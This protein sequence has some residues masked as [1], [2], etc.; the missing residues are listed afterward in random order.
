LAATPTVT[1]Y[2]DEVPLPFSHMT[3]FAGL[4]VE[5][6][7]VLKGPQGTL[8]GE[9]ADGGAIN[10]IAAKPSS[11]LQAGVD[12]SYGRFND[13]DLQGFVSGPLTSTMSARLSA[14]HEGASG[15]QNSISRPGDRNG[16]KNINNARLLIDWQPNDDLKVGLDVNGGVDRSE[17]Q[18]AQF[19]GITIL[20]PGRTRV[21]NTVP[22]LF[23]LPPA[24][25]NAQA[26]DWKAGVPLK[27]NDSQFQGAL[28]INYDLNSNIKLASITSYVIFNEYQPVEADGTQ[29]TNIGGDVVGQVKSF[30]QE[31]RAQ[32]KAFD[33]LSW[34]VGA[35]YQHDKIHE[36]QHTLLPD[37]GNF[38]LGITE[39]DNLSDE[40]VKTKAVYTDLDYALTDTLSAQGGVRYTSQSHSFSGCT[41]PGDAFTVAFWQ[42]IIH[43]NPVVGGCGTLLPSGL[44]GLV[45]SS[46]DE[47]NV[48]WRGNVNWKASEN[49]L[50]YAT[51]SKGYKGGSYP[52]TGGT[53]TTAYRPVHQESI[54]DFEGGIKTSLLDK[55]LQLNAAAFHYDYR[56]KQV[57]GKYI[58]PLVGNAAGALVNVPKSTVNGG[59]LGVTLRPV[60]GLV[61]DL[62]GTYSAT[63]IANPF[64][65][66]DFYGFESNLGGQTLPFAPKWSAVVHANYE[67]PLV[68][69]WLWSV[70]A[71]LDYQSSTFASLGV[72]PAFLVPSHTTLDL[73]AGVSTDD[74]KLSFSVWGRNVTNDY[75]WTSVSLVLDAVSRY[76]A[77]PATYGVSIS[78]RY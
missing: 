58:D 51:A 31:L 45:I 60:T 70:G 11:T 68:Q 22:A 56:G 7:E 61:L 2:V 14:H 5:R 17:V 65:N 29:F 64:L 42:N 40:V 44:G 66:F 57:R 33:K 73:R 54:L 39:N 24:P 47:D 63:K 1:V 3:Q 69:N 46:L 8:Y 77:P 38:S 23:N 74:H 32:G 37:S 55:M 49:T 36:V 72:N 4:D 16:S 35:N 12:A 30:Y 20:E 76:A 41:G 62:Q 21:K 67:H 50:L 18:A 34:I 27:Q 71:D 6:V 28:K 15:W 48:S 19:E 75:Y 25:N 9:N 13:V 52:L 59:E 78:Y 43:T 10:F 26:A 53:S